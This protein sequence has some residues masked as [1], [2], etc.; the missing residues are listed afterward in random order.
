LFVRFRANNYLSHPRWGVSLNWNRFP[1]E[2]LMELARHMGAQF[3]PGLE[4]TGAIDGAIG[5]S[6]AGSFEGE[7]AFHDT[8]VTIP[9]SPPVRFEQ[10]FLL[11]GQGRIH[12]KPAVVRTPG[13][14]EAR[15][16]ADYH[17]DTGTLELS[18]SAEEMHVSSLRA[19]VALAAVPWLEQIR[20]GRW[21]GQLRYRLAPGVEPGWSGR[22]EVREAE[23]AIP[24]L[25]A[26][27]TLERA[28][29]QIEH[30][31]VSLDRIAA[32]VGKLA[33]TG[34]YKYEPDAVR[35]HRFRLVSREIDAA[36]LERILMPTLR[37]RSGFLARALGRASVPE[38]LRSRKIEGS[39]RAAA[40]VFGPERVQD[41]TANLQW[42]VTTVE[43]TD[44]SGR[45]GEADL[46]G[47]VTVNL[48]GSRPAYQVAG[49][50]RGFDWQTGRIDAEGLA[51]THG[52]GIQLVSNLSAE[53]TFTSNALEIAALPPCKTSGIFNL[54]WWQG[55]P[56]LRLKEL[57]MA[58]GDDI[59]TGGG[60]M[61]EDGRL[62]LVLTDGDREMRM[63]GTL[64]ALR[65]DEPV[66]Q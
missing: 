56:R 55:R 54:T 43:L 48:R 9:D 59:Y 26:P 25:A 37:R 2:P 64:D 66:R 1:V 36:E 57:H 6:G 35:P 62:A 16:E 50:V 42:D 44:V 38:W 30:A 49:R 22:L 18:I 15:L 52:T 19:Q 60:A 28:R 20:A 46:S 65:V 27:V 51:E 47:S 3:P 11:F 34:E 4:L 41:V 23:I 8:A 63:S 17:L 32:G 31:R 21:S 5:Y 45:A 24:G 13:D 58:A 53:G 29:A 33:F 10:A 14:D 39:L 61:Q 12:L 7:L 40:V